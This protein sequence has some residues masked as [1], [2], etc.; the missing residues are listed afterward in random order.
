MIGKEEARWRV[1]CELAVDERD[2]KKFME[3]VAEIDRILEAKAQRLKAVR[4]P[5]E[6]S[7]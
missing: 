6:E 1:L 2:P 3:L 4:S 7:D 5:S